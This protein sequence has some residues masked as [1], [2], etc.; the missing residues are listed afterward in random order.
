MRPLTYI[1]LFVLLTCI[2]TMVGAATIDG[3]TITL[4]PEE[5]A[6]CEKGGGCIVVS[7]LYLELILDVI[8]NM[9]SRLD[10]SCI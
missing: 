4:S 9:Q 3:N 8:D 10:K 6:Q 7:N 1:L 2:F 5:S